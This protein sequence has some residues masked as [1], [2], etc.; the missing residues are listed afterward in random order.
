MNLGSLISNAFSAA[1]DFASSTASA[2]LPAM[3]KNG[4]LFD[5]LSRP[6]ANDRFESGSGGGFF[7]KLGEVLSAGGLG[8]MLNA[9]LDALGLPDW[10]GDIAGATLDFCT[11]NYVGAAANALDALEDVAK[12]CGSEELAGFLKTGSQITN[13]FAPSGMA[14]L[15]QLG[16]MAASASKLADQLGA[17]LDA[18]DKLQSSDLAGA[19]A[20]VFKMFGA[21][22][23]NVV[24]R[25]GNDFG[26]GFSAEL[27]STLSAC[28][29]KGE[30]ALGASGTFSADRGPFQPM[31]TAAGALLDGLRTRAD[32]QPPGNALSKEFAKT[33]A[34]AIAQIFGNSFGASALS[35]TM[36]S[37]LDSLLDHQLESARQTLNLCAGDRQGAG[38]LYALL[39]QSAVMS[40]TVDLRSHQAATLRI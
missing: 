20:D 4:G 29:A 26:D 16:D 36:Q 34:S 8:S 17:G 38:R 13:M 5:L 28:F 6:F 27:S 39:R 2:P 14:K 32:G 12:A 19:G 24:A 10:V 25:L 15:G 33:L 3:E 18:V 1:A 35:Q 37:A 21:D 22:T 9:G 7:S 30:Q 40:E 23:G 11:G 31:Q